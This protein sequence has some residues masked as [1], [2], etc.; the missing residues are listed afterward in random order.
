[1]DLL[2]ALLGAATLP[3]WLALV[4]L[5]RV[6][7]AA[8]GCAHPARL[9]GESL[10]TQLF[11]R[12]NAPRRARVLVDAMTRMGIPRDLYGEVLSSGEA[13]REALIA[14]KDPGFAG[15][16]KRAYHLG[17]ERDCSVFE[18]THIELVPAV[19]AAMPAATTRMA[20]AGSRIG[21]AVRACCPPHNCATTGS[22]HR[23]QP[24]AATTTSAL[25]T[26]PVM[27]WPKPRRCRAAKPATNATPRRMRVIASHDAR[28]DSHQALNRRMSPMSRSP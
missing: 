13:T 14:R 20:A 2:R 19:A 4:A 10:E 3:R 5:V 15:L 1:M 9:V 11:D 17:P 28:I 7:S 12:A 25:A 6:L 24:A 27:Y 22:F 16:G 21:T 23:L 18:D 8:L 26:S